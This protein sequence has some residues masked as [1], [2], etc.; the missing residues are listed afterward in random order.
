MGPL[1]SVEEALARV[2]EH[3]RPGPSEEVPIGA[4][5]GR[6]L[7]APAPART[8]LPPFSSSAMDGYAVRSAD[9]PGVLPVAFR[10][11]AGRTSPLALAPGSCAAISTGAVVP[12]G[13]DAVVPLERVRIEGELVEIDEPVVP[14]AHIRVPGGDVRVGEPILGAGSLLGPAQIGALAA[15]GIASVS[16]HVRPRVAVVATGSEL[17]Q[18]G[19]PLEL[20][21]I[22]ESNSWLLAAAL[23]EAG[24][25][26]ERLPVVSDEEDAHRAAIAR[27]LDHDVLVTTGGVSVGPHDLVR[28]VERELGV[29]EVFWG[30]AVKPGKPLS[31]GVRGTTLVFGLPGNPVS[32]LVGAVL[33]VRPALEAVQG[34]PAPS[35]R[36]E[37]GVLATALTPSVERDE[38][39]RARRVSR[40]DET[41]LEPIS[42]QESHMIVRAAAADALVHVPRGDRELA[43]GA[44][45]RYIPLA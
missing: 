20:G 42:G 10:I 6:R 8:D 27:G 7:A 17:Q 11:A 43:V 14:G 4:A 37:H 12:D 1:L 40:G 19:R 25:V 15:A 39:V 41:V 29:E 33:F 34:A 16:C 38:L 45:V 18:P 13:A 22:Y 44:R 5:A 3:A 9:T 21:Q 2:L 36:Y 31:F 23:A 28:A 35:P 24:A 32:A 26:V 30:V